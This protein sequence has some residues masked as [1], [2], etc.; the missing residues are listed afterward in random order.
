MTNYGYARVSTKD[1]DLAI[2]IEQLTAAGCTTAFTF[3]EKMSGA[4]RE[5]P[6]LDRLLKKLLPGDV[7]I[8][9][10]LDRLARSTRDL[11]NIVHDVHSAGAQFK[12][13]DNPALDTT[14][15]H[16]KLLFDILG[17]LAE[18]E[19]KLI[20]ARTTAGIE[21]ARRNKVKFGRKRR[22][23][24]EQK[25]LAAELHAQGV[26]LAAIAERFTTSKQKCC[27]TTAWRAVNGQ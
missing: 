4:V 26:T 18:F 6:Q 11:L 13:L 2:Q 5:R 22:L 21:K 12:A 19:R 9:A 23:S 1:Q 14:S 25:Q 17:A 7:L 24:D 8:V 3:P 10:R 16:G 20:C 27:V 15:I